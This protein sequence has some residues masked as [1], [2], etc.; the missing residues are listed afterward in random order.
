MGEVLDQGA[1]AT[2]LAKRTEW[3]SWFE[4]PDE[5]NA[6][7]TQI[8]LMLL[9]EM[10]ARVLIEERRHVTP[11]NFAFAPVLTHLIDSGYFSSQ[12]LAIRR[13]FDTRPDVI[14]L[15][16]VLDDLK[17]SKLLLTRE[18]FVSFDG[19][20]YEPQTPALE[21]QGFQYTASPFSNYSI[22]IQRHERFDS[23]SKVKADKR[24]RFDRIHDD[25]FARLNQWMETSRAQPLIKVSHK[26]LAH[27][28]E[29][30]A[31]QNVSPSGLSFAEVEAIQRAIVRVTRAI[32]DI[33]LNSGVH[34]EVVPDTPLG[35]FG[36]VWEG[37]NLVLSTSRM[38]AY[39]DEM[40]IERNSW[41][42]NLEKDLCGN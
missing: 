28:A 14:S 33:I 15:R 6:I 34:S 17:K 41:L 38:Q 40:K 5:P 18:I 10:S 16:R 37:D 25:I 20:P 23:L 39:W 1:L 35:F 31:L 24:T 8:H 22:A 19:T 9:S 29:Q 26:Y 32:F 7:Q 11:T 30:S 4:N 13:L 21:K 12:I 3:F 27:A 36:Q 2:Y 42:K